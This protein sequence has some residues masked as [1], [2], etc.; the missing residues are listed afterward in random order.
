[1]NLER[2]QCQRPILILSIPNSDSNEDTDV[3]RF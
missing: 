3:S 1:M 2:V